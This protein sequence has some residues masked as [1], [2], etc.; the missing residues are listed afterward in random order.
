M[1]DFNHNSGTIAWGFP[2]ASGVFL[3]AYLD[4]PF[5]ASRKKAASLFPLIGPLSGGIY[6]VLGC[7]E[8]RQMH[9]NSWEF[10]K[11]VLYPI[12]SRYHRHRRTSMWAHFFVGLVYSELHMLQKQVYQI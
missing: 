3:A 5:Y 2:T 10:V 11:Q 6:I 9:R 12:T 4:D 7:H 1:L 8:T